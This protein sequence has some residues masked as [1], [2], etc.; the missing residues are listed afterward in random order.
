MASK[1]NFRELMKERHSCRKFQSKPIPEETLKE[2]ISISLFSPSWCNSQPW[3]IYVASGN[4]LEEIRKE[5]ISK[6]KQKI[7][8]YADIN[9][10]HR[11]DFSERSQSTMAKFFKSWEALPN[12]NEAEEANPCIFNAPT[13]VYL[14]LNK[15]HIPYSILDLGGLEM[16]IMLAA[17][18]HGV[19]SIPAY[20]TIMYPDVLRKILK[21]SEKEDIVIGIA[22][23]YE[24][25]CALNDHRSEKLTLEEACH[26]YN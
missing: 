15:G 26:F 16:S 10:G 25:K 23:G 20:T 4:T 5:W 19:D 9:P 14:T 6:N 8:G 18:D 21:I 22:L 12:K 7:K 24:E 13:M 3:N 2:I 17:K 11:T 1:Y